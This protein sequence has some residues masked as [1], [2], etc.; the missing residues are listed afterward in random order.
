MGKTGKRVTV[1]RLSLVC[2][3]CY[4]LLKRSSAIVTDLIA[5]AAKRMPAAG[6]VVVEKPAYDP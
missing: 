6:G 2:L 1:P 5:E 4:R 3:V